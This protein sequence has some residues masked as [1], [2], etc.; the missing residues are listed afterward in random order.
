VRQAQLLHEHGMSKKMGTAFMTSLWFALWF[1]A[2]A[3]LFTAAVSDLKTRRIPNGLVLVVLSLGMVLQLVSG[4]GHLWISLLIAGGVF[5][6]GALLTHADVIGG[7]D[8]KM[9]PAATVLLP[10]AAA[11]VLIICIALAGGVLSLFYLGATWLARRGGGT[12]LAAGQPH[13]GASQFDHL[14]RIEVGRMLANEPMPYG[15]AIFGG[16]VSAILIGVVT[17]MSAISCSLSA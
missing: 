16:V 11:P 10:P 6:I 14:V 5:V 8:A 4:R 9:I 3:A 17:C 12:A 15:V 2:L 13:P 7:G 1:G